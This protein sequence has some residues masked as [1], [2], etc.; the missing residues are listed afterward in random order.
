MIL[1]H[2]YFGGFSWLSS[3]FGALP[4]SLWLGGFVFQRLLLLS[5]PAAE[6]QQQFDQYDRWKR[7]VGV[8][9]SKAS[10]WQ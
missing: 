2:L 1:V 3:I 4:S 7:N 5:V 10:N 9:Q 6:P 8:A